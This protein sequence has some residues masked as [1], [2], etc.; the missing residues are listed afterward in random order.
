MLA[1]SPPVGQQAPHFRPDPLQGRLSPP[2]STFRFGHFA[3]AHD[4]LACGCNGSGGFSIDLWNAVAR[5]AHL[6]FAFVEA[7]TVR[8]ILANVKEG[9]GDLA[10]A[11]IS[12]TAQ[13]EQE[14]DFSQPMF[15]SGLQIMVGAETGG[16]LSLDQIGKLLTTGPM[17][18]LL[19]LL[20]LLIVVPAHIAWL[21]ERNH[22][23]RIFATSYMPGIF[24]ALWW[25]TG[26]AAGQQS[27]YPRSG[28]GRAVSAAAA[29]V[30]LVFLAYFTAALTSELTVESLRGGIN[31]PGDLPHHRVGTIAGSTADKYLQGIDVAPHEYTK[32]AEML[33]DLE[34]Q[35]IGAVVFDSPVLMYYA[36][37]AGKGKVWTVGP[38]LRK[39]NYGI[40]FPP[41]SP[42]RKPVNQALLQLR[43]DGTY[44]TLFEKWFGAAGGGK[45]AK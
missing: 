33:A 40:L 39:E 11:A 7:P 24:H 13:R 26:A 27:D 22:A 12:I 2:I 3:N 18:F 4:A 19:M 1:R 16:G 42:L 9:R 17:P 29:L 44:W 20:A 32:V 36:A 35:K 38:V 30:S 10:I 37:S 14:F 23:E 25:A 28:W 31:G 43:E 6:Q 8:D 15:E 21:A 5:Q 34:L 41:G 45:D